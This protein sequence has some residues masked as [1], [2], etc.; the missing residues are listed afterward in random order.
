MNFSTAEFLHKF[1]KQ[2]KSTENDGN[3]LWKKRG[4][5]TESN[6]IK[7]IIDYYD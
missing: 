1:I 2:D 6:K 5:K 3:I 7:S 4:W